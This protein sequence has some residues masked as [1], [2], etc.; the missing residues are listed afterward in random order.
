MGAGTTAWD[1][2]GLLGVTILQL[3]RWAA[4]TRKLFSH[5]S[6]QEVQDQDARKFHS[7]G[8]LFS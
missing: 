7:I 3:H 5:G 2:V 4:Y 1:C 8:D 6:G